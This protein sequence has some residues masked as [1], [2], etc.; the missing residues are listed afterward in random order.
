MVAQCKHEKG[1]NKG[2]L[3]VILNDLEFE[4]KIL[5]TQYHA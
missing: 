2:Y 1:R 4:F 3:F 5:F